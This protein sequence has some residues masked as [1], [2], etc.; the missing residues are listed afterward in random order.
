MKGDAVIR[1]IEANMPCDVR[2]MN[3]L[4]LDGRAIIKPTGPTVKEDHPSPA[5]CFLA[6]I[7]I[8]FAV[9]AVLSLVMI[10]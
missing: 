3:I 8:G 5:K 4:R 10:L 7:T 6:G 9:G 2:A 1:L